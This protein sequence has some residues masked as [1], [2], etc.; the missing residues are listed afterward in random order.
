LEE[1]NSLKMLTE[2]DSGPEYILESSF[3]GLLKD[4]ELIK[5]C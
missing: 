1:T 4:K 5:I 3:R 2:L